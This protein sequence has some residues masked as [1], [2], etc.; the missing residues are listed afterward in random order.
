MRDLDNRILEKLLLDHNGILKTSD[1]LEAGIT[2]SRFYQFVKEA[3]LEKA[4]HGIYIIAENLQDEM[5]LLQAQFPK[6]IYSHETALYL[7]ELAE[8]EPE[9]L[10]VTVSAS[11]NSRGLTQ[12][13]IKVYYAK[14][15]WYRLGITEMDSFGGNRIKVYDL[16]RTICD[17]VRR[18]DDMDIAA[19]NY[20]VRE[21]VKRKDKDFTRLSRYAAELRLERRI[22]EKMGVLF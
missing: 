20:A 6:A 12:K 13:G 2:K 19:F 16:E 3:G 11:Y 17:I 8:R 22:R 4:A 21:Y 7:H 15:E 1:V 5:Y 10:T 14:S 18:Y 9:P